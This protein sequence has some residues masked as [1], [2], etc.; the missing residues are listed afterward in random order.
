MSNTADIYSATERHILTLSV[1]YSGGIVVH[2]H[3][4]TGI[5]CDYG[6]FLRFSRHAPCT[7][8][9]RRL[10]FVT[11]YFCHHELLLD[12]HSAELSELKC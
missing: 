5:C 7:I 12:M 1:G 6:L 11:M 4:G 8:W 2:I 9:T 3:N 10:G